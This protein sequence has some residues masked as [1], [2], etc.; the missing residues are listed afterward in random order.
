MQTM[1]DP[2]TSLPVRLQAFY[3]RVNR[4]REGALDDL[5]ALFA[6]DVHFLNPV[7]DDR[8][9]EAFRGAWLKAFRLYK[10]F[11]FT[12]IEVSGT[13]E[14]FSV[15]FVMNIRFAI[16][17]RL[18]VEMVAHCRGRDGQVHYLRDYFDPLGTLLG[19]VAPLRRLY[20]TVFG[21]LIA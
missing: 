9:I 15:A 12:N 1:A 5:A 2:T 4:E 13:D 17:P 10:V 11:E 7:V 8:G 16:G 20:R 19:P 18:R 3:E 6:P 21:W 14:R